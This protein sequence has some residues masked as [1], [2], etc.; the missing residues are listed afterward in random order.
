MTVCIKACISWMNNFNK[1]KKTALK[2]Q[3]VLTKIRIRKL[4]H[5]K[6]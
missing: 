6:N 1:A 4:I 3:E 5:T 2:I